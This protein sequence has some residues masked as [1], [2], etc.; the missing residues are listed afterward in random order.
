MGFNFQLTKVLVTEHQLPSDTPS[1]VSPRH[2]LVEGVFLYPTLNVD[3]R[4]ITNPHHLIFSRI[5]LSCCLMKVSRRKCKK[6]L[7]VS[8][9][10]PSSLA[11]WLT[12][13]WERFDL[14]MRERE[15]LMVDT[16]N[17]HIKPI[18]L[19][20][21]EMVCQGSISSIF[22]VSAVVAALAA[23]TSQRKFTAPWHHFGRSQILDP[24]CTCHCC[25]GL[26]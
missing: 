8:H 15:R 12:Y 7:R 10:S 26:C 23:F 3:Q 21:N 19:G 25:P 9:L 20:Y 1:R 14:L 17:P 22:L 6:L 4:S 16:L 11:Q 5:R 2:P 24:F 13:V 18:F